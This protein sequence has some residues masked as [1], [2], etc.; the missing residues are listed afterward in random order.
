MMS[1][2]RCCVCYRAECVRDVYISGLTVTVCVY[3][4]GSSWRT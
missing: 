4:R 2:E 1:A 3:F